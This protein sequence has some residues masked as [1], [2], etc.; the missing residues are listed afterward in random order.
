MIMLKVMVK[1]TVRDLVITR[2]TWIYGRGG[3]HETCSFKRGVG[4]EE[5][6]TRY[7]R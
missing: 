5:M 7:E 2:S 1:V 6:K 4:Y 3:I